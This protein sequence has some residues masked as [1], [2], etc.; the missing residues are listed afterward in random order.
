MQTSAQVAPGTPS[1]Q[2]AKQDRAI[3]LLEEARAVLD[4][5]EQLEHLYS[6]QQA[7]SEP[8]LYHV[9]TAATAARRLVVQA[10]SILIDL[11]SRT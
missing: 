1:T 4:C 2:P 7:C 6:E 8:T 9:A 10:Q 3:E 11:G 5:I